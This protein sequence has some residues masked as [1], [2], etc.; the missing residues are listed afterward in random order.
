MLAQTG[1]ALGAA[2]AGSLTA[3]GASAA[4]DA[5]PAPASAAKTTP[6]EP[7]GY[8]FNTSTISGQK[9]G[10]VE[11]IEIIA[12]AGYQG[13]EPWIRELDAYVKEGGSLS[14]LGKR[15]RDVNLSVE[16]VIGFFD[17]IVDDDAKRAKALDEAKRNFE[18]V[19]AIGGK[20][21]AA[22][23]VGAT[24]IVNF[25]LNKAADRY[26]EL[27]VLGQ[28]AGVTPMVEVWGFSKTLGTLGAALMVAADCGHAGAS[29]LPDVYHLFKGG[30]DI[31]GLKLLDGA[32]IGVFHFNDYPANPP[33]AEITD[34]HRVYPGDGVAPIGDLLKI[35]RDIGYRGMLSLEVFNREYWKQDALLVASTGLDKMRT[36]VKKSLA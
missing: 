25:D 21:L 33:R 30:S 31:S 12:R 36:I 32:S 9:L 19:A 18:L 22:P 34:A 5:K 27:L 7:F 24:D 1:L 13:I 10:L 23:P 29:I 26:G 35:L 15:L 16:S 11:E 6:A 8:C 17:W 20:R 2:A 4:A 3:R 14:D 28:K